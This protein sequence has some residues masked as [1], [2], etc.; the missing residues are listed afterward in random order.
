[1][2]DQLSL[3][4]QTWVQKNGFPEWLMALLWVFVSFLMFQTLGPIIFLI[5]LIG[6][7]G[8]EIQSLDMTKLI[9]NHADLLFWGNTTGQVLV[10]LLG[11]LLMVRLHSLP[12][13]RASFIRWN[14]GEKQHLWIWAAMAGVLTLCLQPTIWLLGWLNALLPLPESYLQMEQ[15][16]TQML[17]DY[18]SG[19]QWLGMTIFHIALVPAICE[20]ILFRGYILRAMERSKSIV[21]GIVISGVLF[22]MYHLRFTQILPLSMIGILLAFI[23]WKSRSL[24]PAMVAHFVNN[25]GS[26]LLVVFFPDSSFAEMNP[27]AHPPIWLV[28]LSLVASGV[29]IWSML[30]TPNHNSQSPVSQTSA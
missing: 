29:L 10:I 23:T 12:G 19:G 6:V 4:P 2:S 26:I 21:W 13:E 18:L 11:T 5:L 30:Q 16:Q 3:N 9:Q 1:M 27:N 20:E 25:A 8:V 14:P 15:V 7:R 22:G 17:Q 24:I 28:G